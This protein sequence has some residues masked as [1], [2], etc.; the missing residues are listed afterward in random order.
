MTENTYEKLC[1][2]RVASL[3]LQIFEGPQQAAVMFCNKRSDA[4]SRDVSERC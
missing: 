4:L 2:L 1:F 3:G